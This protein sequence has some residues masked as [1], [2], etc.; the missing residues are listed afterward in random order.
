MGWTSRA[1]PNPSNE[2]V[3]LGAPNIIAGASNILKNARIAPYSLKS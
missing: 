1:D 2:R 3:L